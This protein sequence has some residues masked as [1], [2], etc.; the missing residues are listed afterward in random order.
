MLKSGFMY[1]C[2]KEHRQTVTSTSILTTIWVPQGTVLGLL[3]FTVYINKVII[4]TLAHNSL[5]TWY[6]FFIH[7]RDVQ[8]EFLY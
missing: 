2:L 8:R 1:I 7:T 4:L 6:N 3:V 5:F